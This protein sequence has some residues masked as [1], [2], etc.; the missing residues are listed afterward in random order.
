MIDPLRRIF[1]ILSKEF[2]QMRRDR[3]T[4]GMMIMVPVMQLTLFG[5]AINSDPRHLPTLLYLEDDSA[6][7][8]SLTMGLENSSYFDI[9]GRT[10]RADEATRKLQSGDVA[11]VITVPAGFTRDVLRGDRPQ[12]LIEADGGFECG[13]PDPA[14]RPVCP[15]TRPDRAVGGPRPRSATDGDRRP[16][17]VQSRRHISVQYRAGTFGRHPDHDDDHDHLDRHDA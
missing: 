4:F 1:A 11:F 10:T 14:D 9:I 17:H 2:I 16:P 8:R 5:F 6:V 13:R 12:L 15:E 7:V 3:L